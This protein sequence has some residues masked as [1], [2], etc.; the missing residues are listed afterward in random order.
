MRLLVLVILL[1]CNSYADDQAVRHAL[2]AL[3]EIEQVKATKKKIEKQAI[4]LFEDN[5][6]IT[7]ETAGTIVIVSAIAITGE[8]DTSAAK[9]IKTNIGGFEVVP[10]ISYD[11]RTNEAEG[12]IRSTYEF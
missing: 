8:I 6:P 4:Q 2:Q 11:I 10:R 12:I 5:M 7:K 1:T 9:D 3:S